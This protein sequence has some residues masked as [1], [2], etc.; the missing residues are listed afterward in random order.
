MKQEM[1][2]YCGN[3]RT[4]AERSSLRLVLVALAAL[5][6]AP[7]CSPD[8]NTTKLQYVP[9][10]ADTAAIKAQRDFLNPPEGSVATNA[11]LYPATIEESEKI[12]RNPFPAA[13]ESEAQGKKLYDTFCIS[14]HGDDGKGKGSVTDL[15]PQPPD[16]TNEAYV[17]RQD[18]F[19]F[20]KITFGGAIMPAY[21]Y[22]ISPHERWH[23]VHYVRVLQRAAQ[24]GSTAP[25]TPDNS[26]GGTNP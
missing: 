3:V 13:A 11:I 16:I 20:H 23:I 18:G 2:I 7:G 12:L 8:P 15:Y 25:A 17:T 14:C 9:D 22:S 6:V 19:F 5:V 21:G 26:Q 1:S 24:H 4:A 10:M